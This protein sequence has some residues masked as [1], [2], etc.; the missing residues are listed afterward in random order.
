MEAV[1]TMWSAIDGALTIIPD[2][3]P[4]SA[5]EEPLASAKDFA[6]A[7]TQVKSAL[8]NAA[9]ETFAKLEQTRAELQG[10]IQNLN[11]RHRSHSLILD[12]EIA[13]YVA[14]PENDPTI[15]GRNH[16]ETD[17][18]DTAKV[19][20]GLLDEEAARLALAVDLFHRDLAQAE[21]D[22]ADQIR[23]ISGGDEVTRRDGSRVTTSQTAWGLF[24]PVPSAG[25][26]QAPRSVSLDDYFG[27]AIARATAERIEWFASATD[28][29]LTDWLSSHPEFFATV[30]FIPP[31]EA[32]ALYDRLQSRST[33]DPTGAW[34]TGPLAA[35]WHRAPASIG[36]LN[37]IPAT[38]RASFGAQEL[39][40]LLGDPSLTDDQ[41]T[42]LNLLLDETTKGSRVLS[43]FLDADG[44]VRGS[45][46][47][48]DLDAADQIITVTHGI[49]TDFGAMDEWGTI[50][51]DLAGMTNEQLRLR[52]ID[53]S[54]A[55]VLFMEWD[56]GEWN[57]VQGMNRPI[58]GAD[59]EA[60]LVAGMRFVNPEAWQ[61]GWAHSLGTTMTTTNQTHNPGIF[62]HLT[63]FGSA[64][65]TE[66]SARLL[67]TQI[68][69][70]TV[71]VSAAS[72][73]LDPIAWMGRTDL[74]M[75]PV[76]P[77]TVEGVEEIGAHGGVVEDYLTV[78][79][80]EVRGVATQGHN[81][82]PSAEI[83]YRIHRS[84]Y[85]HLGLIPDDSVGYLDPRS[86]S[87]LQAVADF[88][89]RAEERQ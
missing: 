26:G 21:Q 55:V 50:A 52:G 61:E 87:M 46:F 72:S 83:L 29:D 54:T 62:D 82:G 35:L 66:V 34:V 44:Q 18:Y 86:E 57:T 4:S 31:A 3:S 14:D 28:K 16:P 25:P 2:G 77:K 59:R 23:K 45:L 42:K 79:G 20:L 32:K 53:P 74:S 39:Q 75:H 51:S 48:G 56:S 47:V 11:D 80:Q 60:A 7:M 40:R 41:R 6:E 89:E 17:A 19:N 9:G 78:D 58:L 49:A 1:T 85:W 76:D 33:Q 15:N 38:T 24:P 27:L 69:D 63:L 84:P 68:A 5:L 65:I 88:A 10:T 73:G 67:E 13:K 64:G 8:V 81:A 37:G 70:G 36:N 22:L 12:E 30:G 43:L 71:S